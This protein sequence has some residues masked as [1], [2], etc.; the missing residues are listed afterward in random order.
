M[1]DDVDMYPYTDLEKGLLPLIDCDVLCY[2]C[3]FAADGQVKRDA[4]AEEPEASPERIAEMLASADY[5]HIAL[6][7]VKTV[8]EAIVE[9]FNGD[10]RAF[11]HGSGNFREDLA[12]IKKYKGN[13]DEQAKP[14]YFSEIKQYLVNVWKAKLVD[15]MESDDALG[16][17]QSTSP[18]GTTVIVSNDKDMD[19]IP[20]WH[21]NWVKSELYEV[22]PEEADMMLF[23]QMMVGDS[24]DNIPGIPK[25]GPKTATKLLSDCATPHDAQKLVKEL[26]MKE[27]GDK[28]WIVYSEIANLLWIRRQENEQCPWA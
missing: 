2:R 13:R 6:H 12:T 14:K 9:R 16:I 22:R 7:N 8:M 4:L 27:Y 3:G 20:G 21:F 19:M 26:Y 10:Y 18:Y 11:I 17:Y 28:G 1:N 24:T 23:W 15:G 5:K 25:I